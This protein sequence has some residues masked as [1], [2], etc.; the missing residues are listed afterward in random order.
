MALTRVYS[1]FH[2]TF[3]FLEHRMC[4][5]LPDLDLELIG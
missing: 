2:P 3:T 5:K 4:Q 1:S